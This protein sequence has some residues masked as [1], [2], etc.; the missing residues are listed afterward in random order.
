MSASRSPT[1]K[2]RPPTLPRA[3][4]V[5]KYTTIHP[6]PPRALKS[7]L[8]VIL[9]ILI[10]LGVIKD[11]HL[12]WWCHFCSPLYN[13]PFVK[14][15]IITI[16]HAKWITALNRKWTIHHL[17]SSRSSPPLY[18]SHHH[19]SSRTI[20]HNLQ[21]TLT[22]HHA[23][24]AP[25]STSISLLRFSRPSHIHTLEA[26]SPHIYFTLYSFLPIHTLTLPQLIINSLTFTHINSALNIHYAVTFSLYSHILT[27]IHISCR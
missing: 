8:Y 25:H 22:Y 10:S 3:W 23:T 12:L 15:F 16:M 17:H 18:L 24:I 14:N 2:T 6:H 20:C 27:D 11:H 1:A 26:P 21:S 13:N 4:S 5:T 9:P 19:S 7:Y